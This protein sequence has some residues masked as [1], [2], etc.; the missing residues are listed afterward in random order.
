MFIQY[1]YNIHLEKI[2]SYPTKLTKQN[3]AQVS[4]QSLS[5]SHQTAVLV[6]RTDSGS[7]Q[8]PSYQGAVYITIA[9]HQK[10]N[11][12]LNNSAEHVPQTTSKNVSRMLH[13]VS[14]CSI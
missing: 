1:S 12:K 7:A 9:S 11:N 14:N 4:Y 6:D 3:L 13:M 8:H 2:Q 5:L 10:Y